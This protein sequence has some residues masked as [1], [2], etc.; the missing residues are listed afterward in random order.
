M[1]ITQRHEQKGVGEQKKEVMPLSSVPTSMPAGSS[2]KRDIWKEKSPAHSSI[3]LPTL[4]ARHQHPFLPP[5]GEEQWEGGVQL[6]LSLCV[7][8]GEA[9]AS[10]GGRAV[11]FSTCCCHWAAGW[12]IL[13]PRHGDGLRCLPVNHSWVTQTRVGGKAGQLG[14][15]ELKRVPAETG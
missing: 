6:R 9:K 15:K 7:G 10:W 11:P 8:P 13:G 1:K 14:E 4:P 3:P 5:L 12:G 2:W